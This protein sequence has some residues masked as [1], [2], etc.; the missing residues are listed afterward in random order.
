M[1]QR[2]EEQEPALGRLI[3]ATPPWEEDPLK[4]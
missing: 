2:I 1:K 4:R 3:Q